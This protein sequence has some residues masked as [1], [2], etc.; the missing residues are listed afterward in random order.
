MESL[1][2]CTS[3]DGRLTATVTVSGDGCKASVVTS[4][5]VRKVR[6]FTGECAHMDAHRFAMDFVGPFPYVEGDY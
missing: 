6:R 3:R 4:A 2:T 1:Y 5:V